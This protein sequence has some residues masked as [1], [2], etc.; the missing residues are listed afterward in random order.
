M[1][2]IEHYEQLKVQLKA[3]KD[4]KI[5]VVRQQVSVECQP[6]NQEIEQIK[7][8]TLN[9]LL[10][11]YNSNKTLISQQCN[12]QL[13]ALEQNYE[14]EKKSFVEKCENKKAE[15]FNSALQKATYK[16]NSEYENAIADIDKLINN[17]TVKE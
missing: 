6:K 17:L 8:E 13:I 3:E 12:N 2:I 10:S 7:A 14:N 5:A 4:A 9:N 15:I 11:E 1:S 16:I